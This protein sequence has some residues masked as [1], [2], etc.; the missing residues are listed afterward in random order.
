MS[1]NGEECFVKQLNNGM[2][3]GSG[4]VKRKAEL[5]R[6]FD[7]MEDQKEIILP[8]IDDVVFLEEQLMMLRKL[9]QI[10][11][12]PDYPDIQKQTESA[13]LYIKLFQQY[14]Q[15]IKTLTGILRKD[16][17]EEESPLREYLKRIKDR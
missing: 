17:V 3:D 6:I 5:L 4:A 1:K 13:K 12:H 16:A 11:V 8:M 10:R 9:P 14:N 7:G 15:A 2:D